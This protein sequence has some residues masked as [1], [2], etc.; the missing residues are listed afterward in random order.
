MRKDCVAMSEKGRHSGEISH[1]PLEAWHPRLD[2]NPPSP[3]LDKGG[4]G[5]FKG[6]FLTKRESR[7]NNR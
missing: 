5:G 2:E 3:P 7:I 6:V 4:L 1:A